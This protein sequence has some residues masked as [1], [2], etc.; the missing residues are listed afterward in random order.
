M[1]TVRSGALLVLLAVGVLGGA[2]CVP[3]SEEEEGAG[4]SGG[5]AGDCPGWCNGYHARC[6]DAG[7][8]PEECITGCEQA[9]AMAVQSCLD[10]YDTYYACSAETSACDAGGGASND[11]CPEQLQAYTNC[12][13]GG[14]GGGGGGDCTAMPA[15]D[16][17]CSD[18]GLPPHAMFCAVTPPAGCVD[19]SAEDN[20]V[21]C[22]P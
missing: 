8:T 13:Q 9:R 20:G 3:A 15:F 18:Q 6:P 12:T 22:C 2:A 11:P 4:G 14:A 19:G 1:K 16:P 5:P 17:A 7:G 10:E 21:F